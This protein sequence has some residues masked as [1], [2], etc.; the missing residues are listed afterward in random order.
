MSEAVFFLSNILNNN[1]LPW[2]LSIRTIAY[3]SN[4]LGTDFCIIN[5]NQ[6]VGVGRVVMWKSWK[7]SNLFM[8]SGRYHKTLSLKTSDILWQKLKKF[9]IYY[10]RQTYDQFNKQKMIYE[11]WYQ[12][13]YELFLFWSTLWNLL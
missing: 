11:L 1:N 6:C 10:N 9:W 7:E 3:I 8:G 5:V 2:M 12:M 13:I 4:D